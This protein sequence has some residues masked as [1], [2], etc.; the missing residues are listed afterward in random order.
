MA[1]GDRR[2]NRGFSDIAKSKLISRLN[3]PTR[4]LIVRAHRQ[5]GLILREMIARLVR[6]ISLLSQAIA[7]RAQPTARPGEHR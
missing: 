7:H 5:R 3:Q 1:I 2:S 4:E 6:N